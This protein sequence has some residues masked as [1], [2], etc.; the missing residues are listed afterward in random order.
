MRP[1]KVLLFISVV[2]AVIGALYWIV[3]EDWSFEHLIQEW[4]IAKADSI[5]ETEISTDTIEVINTVEPE[6]EKIIIPEVALD[7]TVDSRYY[8]QAFYQS[9]AESG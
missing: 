5:P 1:Y 7:S 4:Q 2:M 9:L 3:P 6:K 8:L